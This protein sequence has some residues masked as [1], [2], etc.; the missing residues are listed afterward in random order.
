MSATSTEEAQWEAD[1]I[2]PVLKRPWQRRA[3]DPTTVHAAMLKLGYQEERLD[4]KGNLPG[5]ALR[6]EPLDSRFE[7]SREA[8]PSR[9]KGQ[10]PVRSCDRSSSA[11]RGR[12]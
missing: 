3:W 6:V 5:G 8:D 7:N 1:R 2:E 9:R 10:K 12:G 4:V 11:V